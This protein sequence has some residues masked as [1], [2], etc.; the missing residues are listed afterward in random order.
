[1]SSVIQILENLEGVSGSNAKKDI[2]LVNKKNELLKRV[3]IAAQDPYVVY[4]VNKFR[5]PLVSPAHSKLS[6][7][8][9][10]E[11]FLDFIK[12]ELSTRKLTGNAA[13]HAVIQFFERMNTPEM[14]KWC[15]RILLKNL[16]VGVQETTVNKVWPGIIKSFSVALANTLKCEFVKG[17]G[18]KIL[19][20]VSYPVRVEPKLDGLRCIAV[21]CSGKVTLYTRNGTVLETLDKIR[22][23]LEAA[24]YDDVVL[25]GECMGKDW[26]ESASVLMSSKSK[27]D[28]SN[29]YYNVFDALE[30]SEWDAQES[31]TP[32]SQRCELVT[33]VLRSLN[34]EAQI[35]QVSHVTAK[36]EE[37]LKNFFK[38][39]M[40]EGYEGVMLKDTHSSYE[41]KRSD[42]ILKLK[43][44]TSYE[45]VIVGHYEGRRGTKREGLFSGFEVLLPNGVVT[46]VGSG[47]NDAMKSDVQL[48]G[49]DS[50]VGK[51]VE[52]EAQ[53]DPTTSDGL[54]SDGK[55][56]FPV[57]L[58]FR[59]ESDV[60]PAVVKAAVTWFE[61]R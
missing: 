20:P 57:F 53:P 23:N 3:F 16:R 7:D 45:G 58:R 2:L 13:K 27:K 15:L 46:R 31:V 60:D 14:Q 30:L 10:L 55:A 39:C 24:S 9:F 18:M 4:Y 11:S 6:D 8:E 52:I 59:S 19:D 50:Y 35:R 28:D 34:K 47:F 54:T 26:A 42:N 48:N 49:G 36:N 17:K 32:Y 25:D 40:D 22:E 21:K 51:I 37:E 12:N 33:R 56:R 43:P 29:M 5:M 61:N 38:K 1:M 41:F 44:Y